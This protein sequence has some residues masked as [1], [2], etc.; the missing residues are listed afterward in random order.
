[1]FFY[2]ASHIIYPKDFYSEDISFVR[3]VFVREFI[4][5]RYY[6]SC[7]YSRLSFVTV[8]PVT[9]SLV[10]LSLPPPLLPH[11]PVWLGGGGGWGVLSPVGNHIL[12]E[13]NTLCRPRFRTYKISKP[14]RRKT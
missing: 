8:A 5:W 14:P 3:Q 13:F 10:Q 9:F 1:M 11:F 2:S 4:D 7:W 12:K 6:Q